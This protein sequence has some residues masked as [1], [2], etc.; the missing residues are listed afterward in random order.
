MVTILKGRKFKDKKID[1]LLLNV[2]FS[3]TFIAKEYILAV[4]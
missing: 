2:R 4:I 3:E 1:L